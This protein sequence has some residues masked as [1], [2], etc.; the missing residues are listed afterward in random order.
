MDGNEW[1]IRAPVNGFGE[2]S[3]SNAGLGGTIELRFAFLLLYKV[4]LTYQLCLVLYQ[5]SNHEITAAEKSLS[6]IMLLLNC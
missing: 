3:V 5:L 6:I 1:E 2:P 4:A